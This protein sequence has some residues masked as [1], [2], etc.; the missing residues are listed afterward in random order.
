M[1]GTH[2]RR[3]RLEETKLLHKL[4]RRHG[5][6][7]SSAL[8]QAGAEADLHEETVALA[9]HDPERDVMEGFSKAKV[10]VQDNTEDKNM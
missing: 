9:R 2:G 5:G 4:R 10:L 8:A 7:S 3:A 6:T 1:H